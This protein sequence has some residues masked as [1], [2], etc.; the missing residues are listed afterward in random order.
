MSILGKMQHKERLREITN[1]N[2]ISFQSPKKTLGELLVV[3][4][5]NN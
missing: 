2:T 1:H 4:P 3:V 5:T